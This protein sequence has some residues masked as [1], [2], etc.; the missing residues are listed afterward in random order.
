MVHCRGGRAAIDP[1]VYADV[2]AFWT[3]L[4]QAYADQVSAVAKRGCRYLDR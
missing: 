4:T 3:D 2:D 1:S